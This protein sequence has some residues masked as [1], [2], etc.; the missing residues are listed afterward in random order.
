M[1]ATIHQPNFMP[2]YPFFQKLETADVFV[3]LTHCQF[4]KNNF[5]NRFNMNDRW[6][7][8]SVNKG[9]D[10]ICEKQY[11]NPSRDWIKMKKGLHGYNLEIFDDC[12]SDNLSDTNIKIIKKI[13]NLLNIETRII[14]DYDTNY[15]GTERLINICKSVG[16]SKYISGIGGRNYMD[17][18]LFLENEIELIFQDEE[19]MIKKPILQILKEKNHV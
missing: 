9:L 19:N 1:I 18:N 4:E 17:I 10:N 13:C 5:Q 3:F 8:M 16:A 6:L 2:W 7:T 12:I 11:A 14:N 15:K